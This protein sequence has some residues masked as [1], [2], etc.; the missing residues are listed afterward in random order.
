V[1]AIVGELE[2]LHQLGARGIGR[3]RGARGILEDEAQR[4]ELGR[5][6]RRELGAAAV[7]GDLMRKLG[8]GAVGGRSARSAATGARA[9]PR[10]PAT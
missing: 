3:R 4:T 10:E 5:G 9:R 2:P 8:R 1:T 7:A 6:V